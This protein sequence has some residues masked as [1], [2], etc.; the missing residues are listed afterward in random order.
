MGL[1][2]HIMCANYKD[3]R[4]I[5]RQARALSERLGWSLDAAPDPSADVNYLLAYFEYQR[6]PRGWR[7]A[8][9]ANFTHREEEPPNNA[10]A[11]LWDRVAAAV[12]LRITMARMYYDILCPHGPTALVHQNLER[13]HFQIAPASPRARLVA[14]FSGYTYAN[15]RKGEDLAK[16]VIQSSVGGRLEWR[17]SGRGWPVP[18]R[19]Y[20]WEEMPAFYQSLDILVNTSRVEGGPLPPLEALACGCSVVI[21]RH[22]GLLDDIPDVRGI[23][24]YERGDLKTLLAALEQAI[25]ERHTVDRAALREAVAAWSVEAW[26][27][28]HRRAFVDT[29]CKE[30]EMKHE[31]PVSLPPSAPASRRGI[32]CVAFGDPAREAAI[33]LM[34]TAKRHMPDIP[35]ALCA[36]KPIGIEDVFIQGEDTDIGAR[37]AKIRMYELSPQEWDTVLYLDADIEITAPVYPIF[38]WVEDGWDMVATKDPHLIDTM[39]SYARVN[40]AA[41]MASVQRACRTLDAL[42]VA[43]GV[44]AFRRNERVKAFFDAWLR[45]WEVHGQRDQGPLVRALYAHPV[46]LWLLGNEW[47]TFERY[48]PRE[49]SAGI[50]HYPGKA[51]RW[52][53]MVPGRTDSP[54]AWQMVQQFMAKRS[55]K[56]GGQ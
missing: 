4:I 27:D 1:R 21:P 14:G 16:L 26:V 2:V 23:Y 39:R 13:H 42:Q 7:G 44:I 40:N 17:A 8:L 24:R 37:R 54:V 28:D 50:M 45:E 15:Q 46:R 47:N 29:F 6:L 9:A 56:R 48:L 34:K 41:D 32:Y 36:A 22:V 31:M 49:R 43:G 52:E 51:R 11:R 12:Q 5:P 19:R 55:K 30:A 38:Q 25:E 35:I 10:K 33:D 53:G 20:T 3:D 18:T